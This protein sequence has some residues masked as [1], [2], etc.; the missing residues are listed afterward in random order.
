MKTLYLSI[1]GCI[2]VGCSK[3]YEQPRP[4]GIVRELGFENIIHSEKTVQSSEGKPVAYYSIIPLGN[5][6]YVCVEQVDTLTY[7]HKWTNKVYV[8][9]TTYDTIKLGD[10]YY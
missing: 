5:K 2:L 4:Q 7:S 9:K 3:Q 8:T 1:V 10:L 6:Y